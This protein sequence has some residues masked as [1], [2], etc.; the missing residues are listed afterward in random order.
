MSQKDYYEI[1]GVPRSASEDEIRKAYRKLAL[2]YHPDRNKDKKEAEGKFKEINEAY[3][4]LSDKN[5][6]AQYDRFGHTG[7]TG[8]SFDSEE[9][10]HAGE[11]FGHLGGI[12]GDLFDDVFTGGGRR[13]GARGQD[14]ILD[15]SIT[16]EEAAFGCKKEVQLPRTV[17][18]KECGGKGGDKSV[19]CDQCGGSGKQGYSQGF[20]SIQQTC[21]GCQ[22][23]GELITDP[24]KQCRGAGVVRERNNVTVSIPQGV[25]NGTR[26]RI[27][28]EG[29]APQDGRGTNGDLYIR[30]IVSRHKLFQREGADLL[31]NTNISFIQAIKGDEISIPSLKGENIRFKIP[32]GTQ[33]GTV[34]R[35][36]EKGIK[37]MN[38][39]TG[40]LFVTVKVEIPKKLS[41]Q[42]KKL[43]EELAKE[44]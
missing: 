25:D 36:K 18:C 34:L 35:L 40:D 20:F 8:F 21:R 23:K 29:Q 27:R 12:F 28:G 38:G 4:V 39:G 37:R 32:N 2:K 15:L 7:G 31:C 41:S 5:K 44:F 42:Q 33:P 19:R 1:I 24:C 17:V 16:F 30:C 3:Q 6:K 13:E 14:I 10:F 11:G 43:V 26:L 9:G 22:G